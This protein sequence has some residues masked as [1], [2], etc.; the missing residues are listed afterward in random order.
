M[1]HLYG[2]FAFDFDEPTFHF[3]VSVPGAEFYLPHDQARFDSLS[4]PDIVAKR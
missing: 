1:K 2:C 4:E 3:V